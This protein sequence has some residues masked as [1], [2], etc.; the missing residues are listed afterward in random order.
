M[1]PWPTPTSTISVKRAG[2]RRLENGAIDVRFRQMQRA[3][4]IP[5]GGVAFEIGGGRFVARG[6]DGV[7]ALGVARQHWIVWIEH[8]E[9]RF[10]EMTLGR[11]GARQP[12]KHPS[13]LRRALNQ[14]RPRSAVSNAG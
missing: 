14:A 5:I 9:R 12:V 8:R 6:A 4:A 10:G 13:A 1:R 2:A 11:V 7:Q 3:H